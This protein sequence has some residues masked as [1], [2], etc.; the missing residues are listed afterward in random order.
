MIEPGGLYLIESNAGVNNLY[1]SNVIDNAGTIEKTAGSGTSTLA[2]DGPLINTGTIEAESGTLSLDPSSFSQVSG[3]TLTGGTWN[4]VDGS[5]LA[6]PSG[7][8]I[9]TNQANVSMDGAGA[10]V[11]AIAGLTSNSGSL[12]LAEGASFSTTG[13]LSNTGSLTIGAGSTLTVNGNYSQGPAGSLTVGGGGVSSGNEYG[14]LNVAGSA[15]LAWI[16]M[17]K[18]KANI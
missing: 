18:K 4:A 2:V 8:S 12:S 13:D 14:Q 11:S 10:S 3:N 1:N 15:T 17:Q 7:T 16:P 9:T 5:T 6:F